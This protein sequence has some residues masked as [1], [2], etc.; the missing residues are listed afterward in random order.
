[1]GAAFSGIEARM[2]LLFSK[3][4]S[5]RPPRTV[6][7]KYQQA[8]DDAAHRH[9]WR[10]IAVGRVCDVCMMAQAKTEFDEAVLCEGRRR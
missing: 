1:M 3:D 8:A 7:G 9:E 5:A 2:S 4:V 6:A 10:T